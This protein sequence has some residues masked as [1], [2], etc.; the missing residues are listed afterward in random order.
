MEVGTSHHIAII[1]YCEVI[2][3]WDTQCAWDAPKTIEYIRWR[4]TTSSVDR[5]R[6]LSREPDLGFLFDCLKTGVL[7]GDTVWNAEVGDEGR[8][9]IF[10]IKFAHINNGGSHDLKVML[11]SALRPEKGR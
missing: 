1:G 3:Q 7:P 8:G 4:S 10:L 2:V 11:T 6:L 5:F 9:I